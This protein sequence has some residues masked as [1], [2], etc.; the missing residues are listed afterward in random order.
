MDGDIAPYTHRLSLEDQLALDEGDPDRQKDWQEVADLS[1][2]AFIRAEYVFSCGAG[3]R[4]FHIDSRGRLN[5]CIMLRQPAYDILEMGFKE[6][7]KKMGA[8]RQLKRQLSTECETCPLGA[9]CTQCPG[10]SQVVHGDL[11]TPVDFICQLAKERAKRLIYGK[12]AINS[13]EILSY[14]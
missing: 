8:E 12:I 9:L 11:E 1:H 14:E 2:G 7:W 6:T 5:M 13:E 3:Y 10:W 4:S